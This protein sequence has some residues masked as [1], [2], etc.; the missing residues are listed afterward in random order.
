[1]YENDNSARDTDCV[2]ALVITNGYSLYSE[3]VGYTIYIIF[4]HYLK[5][6]IHIRSN[7]KRKK[8]H[9]GPSDIGVTRILTSL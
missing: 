9:Y 7:M 2:F 4:I 1:M 5:V 6:H 8:K 3:Y